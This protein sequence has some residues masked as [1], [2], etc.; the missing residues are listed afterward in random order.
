[1][2]KYICC[3]LCDL[4]FDVTL[5]ELQCMTI[6]DSICAALSRPTCT[7]TCTCSTVVNN[8]AVG[9]GLPLI[10]LHECRP[11]RRWL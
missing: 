2:N 10:V 5:V 1:M 8:G 7:Y 4:N 11:S 3:R 9:I 6:C